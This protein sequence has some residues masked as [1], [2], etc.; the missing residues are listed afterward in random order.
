MKT[1]GNTETTETRISTRPNVRISA[2]NFGPIVNGSIDLRPLTVLVGPSNTG[3]TYL[4]T[5]I[6]ALH[7][8]L[9]DFTLLPVMYQHLH[10]FVQDLGDSKSST[11]D[12]YSWEVVLQDIVE[13]LETKGRRFMFADL[14]EPVRERWQTVLTDSEVLGESLATEL[15]RCFGLQSVSE[16]VRLSTNSN[17]AQLSLNVSE[18]CQ[19]LWNFDM[20]VSAS[21]INTDGR[22][23]DMVLFP[24]GGAV[25][26]RWGYRRFRELIKKTVEEFFAEL[27]YSATWNDRQGQTHYLP[28]ARSGIMLSHRLISSSLVAN[29]TRAGLD[30]FPEIPTFSGVVADFLQQLILHEEGRATDDLMKDLADALER[31]VLDGQIRVNR[32]L[33]GGIPDFVY[34]PRKT[35]ENIRLTRASSMVTELAPVVLLLR[36]AIARGDMLII[37]EP[38]AH[39]HPEMQV[40]F[41]RFLASVVRSGVRIVMTTHSEWVLEELANLVQASK[42]TKTQRKEINGSDIALNENEVGAWLFQPKKRPKG[43]VVEEIPL[44]RESGTFAAGYDKVAVD[45]YNRWTEISSRT[46]EDESK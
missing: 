37:D 25:T 23:Q 11:G 27:L 30:P 5:L 43:S 28:A 36:N 9:P 19:S 44:N 33:A 10:R 6:Y 12:A 4:A 38:E 7:K 15:G 24:D 14:P 16:L 3:K 40:E 1:H 8:I 18:E 39:L 21:G 42:L 45:V 29:A 26:N 2:E 22:L 32:A 13:K 46:D 31:E 17:S 20:K 35:E 34:Q 41:T